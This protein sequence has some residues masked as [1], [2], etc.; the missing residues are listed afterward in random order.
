MRKKSGLLKICNK[1]M[2]I[3]SE[4][5]LTTGNSDFFTVYKEY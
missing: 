4:Q 2:H 5:Y 3:T 1:D